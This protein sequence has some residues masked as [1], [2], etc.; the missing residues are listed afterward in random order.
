MRRRT[1]KPPDRDPA[2][3]QDLLALKAKASWGPGC[4]PSSW[5]T[6]CHPHPVHSA[7][8][9]AWE[10]VSFGPLPLW[11]VAGLCWALG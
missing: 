6:A 9:D 10:P 8:G 1:E 4:A 2:V 5:R 3:R 11:N 7:V